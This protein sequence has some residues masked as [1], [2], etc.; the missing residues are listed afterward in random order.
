MSKIYI[1]I[2]LITIFIFSACSKKNDKKNAVARVYNAYLYED[3]LD[4][5]LPDNFETEDS[6][7]LVKNFINSWAKEQLLLKKAE[8]NLGSDDIDIDELVAKYRQDI[9]IN[10]YK[11]AVVN[12]YLDTIVTLDDTSNFY[13][14]NKEI[15]K[16]NEELVQLKYIHFGNEVLNQNEFVNLFKSDKANDL[17]S[18]KSR[19]LQ[20]KS[21]NL[22]DSIWIRLDDILMK[23]P[24]LD[25]NDRDRILKK[26]KFFQK[27]DSLGVYLVAVKRALRRNQTAPMSYVQPTIKQMILHKRRLELFKKIEETLVND[28]I[29]NKEFEM[30]EYDK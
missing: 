25:K 8:I 3:D 21:F 14:E 16:L 9:L 28:A 27:K 30:Y 4:E 26:T 7:I 23:L 6:I 11:G 17:D 15:F 1:Y 22:N 24:I 12:Q 20:F 19:E 2:L 5:I 13:K 29:S 10:K 18:L